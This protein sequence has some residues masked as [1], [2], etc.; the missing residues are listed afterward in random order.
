M[1]RTTALYAAMTLVLSTPAFAGQWMITRDGNLLPRTS[2]AKNQA[3]CNANPTAALAFDESL[4]S[5]PA[6]GAIPESAGTVTFSA[7]ISVQAVC[8]A[9]TSEIRL[10]YGDLRSGSAMTP[11]DYL[12]PSPILVATGAL[13]QFTPPVSTT[14]TGNLQIVNDIVQEAS[15]SVHLGL[16]SGEIIVTQTGGFFNILDLAPPP[17]PAVVLTIIDDDDLNQ[18][19]I[20]NT[21][22][23]LAAGDPVASAAIAPFAATCAAEAARPL[24]QQNAELIAQCRA[25]LNNGSSTAVISA[26]RAI[27]GEEVSSQ[28]TSS[29][30]N[31]NFMTQGV[32]QRLAALRGGATQQSIEDIAFNINGSRIPMGLIGAVFGL[33]AN[34]EDPA[35]E[36][37]VGGGLLDSRLGLFVNVTARDGDR[38]ANAFEVGFDYEGFQALAGVDYRFTDQ[39]VAGLA[40]GFGKIDTDLEL[41]AGFLDTSSSSATLY[42]S[43]T[44]ADNWYI[45]AALGYMRNDYDQGRTVDLTALGG[46][47]TRTRA[48]GDTDGRQWSMAASVGYSLAWGEVALTPNVRVAYART[49]IDGFVENGSGINDLIFPDQDFKSLQYA[50]GANLSRAISLQSG[51]LS[52]Y[53]TLELAREQKNDAYSFSPLL[54]IRPDRPSTP[55]FINES[56]RTFGRG[57]VGLVYLRP[58]GLQ[59]SFSY[60]EM[61]GYRDLNA[62]N[63][64]LGLRLEF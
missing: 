50:L 37:P 56:D 45:D 36:A 35:D 12:P 26:L 57:E 60:S 24:T 44:P 46:G 48:L 14:A 49:E 59:W 7:S 39:F 25:I 58:G 10:R 54:R 6:A 15:E 53:L 27:S 20:T 4:T 31:A 33:S 18:T 51:V 40:L 29:Q 47:F 13:P 61:L 32:S 19:R 5:T 21:L 30:D 34:A 41:N 28:L 43:M 52:P 9:G 1:T 23:P 62:R 64:Q 2:L 17:T 3:F 11:A 42:A 55:V 22:N 63:L 8:L 38:D 16:L